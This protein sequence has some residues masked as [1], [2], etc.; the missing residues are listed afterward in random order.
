MESADYQDVIFFS[1]PRHQR[2]ADDLFS[3]LPLFSEYR[4]RVPIG[5]R[6]TETQARPKFGPFTLSDIENTFD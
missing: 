2:P 5:V 3:I 6:D 1:V 4:M